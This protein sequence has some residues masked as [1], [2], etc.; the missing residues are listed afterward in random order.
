LL[1]GQPRSARAEDS[2][3]VKAQ[4]WQEDNNRIRVDSQYAQVEKDLGT[5]THCQGHG[6]YRFDCRRHAV[7]RNNPPAGPR[8]RGGAVDMK[9]RRKAWNAD[10][11]HQFPAG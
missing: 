6:A 9:D 4:S 10:L 7:R 5:D 8:F 2:L 1:L 11:S 3:T